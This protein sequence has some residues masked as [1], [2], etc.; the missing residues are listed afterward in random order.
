MIDELKQPEYTGENRCLPCTGV[1]LLI[2]V[3]AAAVAGRRS[4][5]AGAGVFVASVVLIYLRGYLVPGTPA[6]TKR[7]L[8]DDVLRLFGKEPARPVQSGLG[9]GLDSDGP[10]SN[11]VGDGRADDGHSATD[12]GDGTST[13]ESATNGGVVEAARDEAG[14]LD[15]EIVLSN[16]GALEACDDGE[17]LCLTE[18]FKQSWDDAMADFDGEESTDL[19]ERLVAQ[20]DLDVEDCEIEAFDDG[21]VLTDGDG[22]IGQWPSEAAMIA[23][24][25]GAAVLRSRLSDWEA[26]STREKGSLLNGLRLFLEECPTGEGGIEFGQETVESCCSSYEVVAVTCEETGD[27]LFEEPIHE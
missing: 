26:L 27:R 23:D 20:F 2:A 3:V 21:R 8:P 16:A 24:A 19:A 9:A 13:V 12:D 10:S 18:E 11:G 5:K 17:D 1:N 25:A 6:L 22:R 7:Y 14:A 15:P 4:R